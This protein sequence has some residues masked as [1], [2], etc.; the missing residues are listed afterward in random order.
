MYLL[1]EVEKLQKKYDELKVEADKKEA[2]IQ[3]QRAELQ[4]NRADLMT[5]QNSN[6]ELSVA[7]NMNMQKLNHELDINKAPREEKEGVEHKLSE[8]TTQNQNFQEEVARLKEELKKFEGEKRY[9]QEKISQLESG[10][11]I[12]QNMVDAVMKGFFASE[13]WKNAQIDNFISSGKI[14]LTLSENFYLRAYNFELTFVLISCS[15]GCQRHPF[16][17]PPR[18]QR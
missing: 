5:L 17:T 18:D 8:S 12:N 7:A 2:I 15:P 14:Q 1:L 13:A 3:T 11:K 4:K 16:R 9:F 10:Q 6:D